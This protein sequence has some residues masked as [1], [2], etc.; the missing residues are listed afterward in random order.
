MREAG[1]WRCGSEKQLVFATEES[2]DGGASEA[3]P[4]SS[5]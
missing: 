2:W 3:M 1:R 5:F 4:V